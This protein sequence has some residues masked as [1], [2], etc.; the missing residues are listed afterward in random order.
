MLRCLL[1]L[2]LLPIS[3]HAAQRTISIRPVTIQVVD[4]ETRK[5]LEGVPVF[6]SLHTVVFQRYVFFVIPNIEPEIGPKL[7]YKA[8]AIT[9][10]DGKVR[11]HAKDFLLPK[12]ERFVGEEIFVNIDADMTNRMAEISQHSLEYYYSEGRVRRI[13]SVD[14]LDI[15]SRY[16]MT[17]TKEER[18]QVL[19]NPAA[20]YSGA[21]LVSMVRPDSRQVGVDRVRFGSDESLILIYAGDTLDKSDDFIVA[22]VHKKNR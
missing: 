2:V 10:K 4:Q 16:V 11:F 19:S 12:N 5:P 8:R 9:D 17:G 7:A 1:Y 21:V 14:N 3:V 15:V 6:Y 13:D 18:N 22:E 20:N